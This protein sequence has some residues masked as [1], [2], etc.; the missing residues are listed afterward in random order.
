MNV[1]ELIQD[2]N[3]EKEEGEIY[4]ANNERVFLVFIKK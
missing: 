3:M 1:Y 4:G 2:V